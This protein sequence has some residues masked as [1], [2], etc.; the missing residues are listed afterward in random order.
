[1]SYLKVQILKAASQARSLRTRV[2]TT[3]EILLV[4]LYSSSV[5][6]SV[7]DR[8][9]SRKSGVYRSILSARGL[10]GAPHL[11]ALPAHTI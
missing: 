3:L 1:M 6:T 10:D 8:D 5:S 9:Y 2:P 11:L 7:E 4:S